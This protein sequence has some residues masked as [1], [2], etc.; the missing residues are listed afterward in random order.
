[1][2]I[3]I[4]VVLSTLLLSV[5]GYATSNPPPDA[6]QEL[7]KKASTKKVIKHDQERA[8]NEESMVAVH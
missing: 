1:M 4:A 6:K 8:M 2:S 3:G 7:G 5:T